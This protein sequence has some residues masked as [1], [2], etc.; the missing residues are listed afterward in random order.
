M[1]LDA[2][3]VVGVAFVVT[4]IAIFTTTIYLHRA[5]THRGVTFCRPVNHGFKFVTWMTTGIRPRQWV[6]VHRKHH[7]HT[8]TTEDPHSPLILGWWTV[9]SRNVLLYRDAAQDPELVSKYAKDLPRTRWDRW[10][11]DHALVGLGLLGLILVLWLGPIG[12]LLALGIHAVTYLALSGS[13]NGP[14]HH[15]GKKTFEDNS[16]TNLRWLT[17][18]TAGEGLHNHHHAAP[19]SARFARKFSD[20]DF[21]WWVIRGASAL[22]LATVRHSD[23]D[24]LASKVSASA[25]RPRDETNTPVPV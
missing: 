1:L 14:G 4:Q 12:G 6:A 20:M 9:Q 23:V 11:F 21:G 17:W 10:L 19:T 7:A 24:M 25:S 13:V 16:A 3:I 8:D 18:L 5:L 22:R 2:L 15:F